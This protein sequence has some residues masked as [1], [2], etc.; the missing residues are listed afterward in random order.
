VYRTI[1]FPEGDE[2]NAFPRIEQGFPR[3]PQYKTIHPNCMHVAVPFLWNQKTDEQKKKELAQSSRPFDLDPRGERERKRYEDAQRKNA[4]RLR[5]RKQWERY[6]AVLGK[7]NTPRT[8]SAFRS[9]KRANS[10]KWQEL[11]SDY[12]EVLKILRKEDILMDRYHANLP[13]K[14]E[15]DSVKDLVRDDGTVKQRRYYGHDGKP[16]K[17]LDMTDHGN[18]KLHPI[19]PHAHDWPGGKRA[20][21][22]REWTEAEKRQNKDL[23]GGD[24]ND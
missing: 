14:A 20:K 21:H 13:M 7:E 24:E 3:W 16:Q 5:D 6:R 4:E 10:E 11:T 18:P 17:D 22:D 2:R 12:R 23:L 1:D 9:M 19:V 15:P 8:L